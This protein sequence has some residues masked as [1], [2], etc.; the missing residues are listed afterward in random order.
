MA[1]KTEKFCLNCGV[2]VGGGVLQASGLLGGIG[3]VALSAWKTE[4][5]AAATAAAEKAGAAAGL[6]AG[7]AQGMAIVIHFLE[8]WGIKEFC[9]GLFKSIGNT[10]PYNDSA[11]IISAILAKKNAACSAGAGSNANAAIG[12]FYIK[13]DKPTCC[14]S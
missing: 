14:T 8:K 3:E 9:P 7:N 5:I 13:K 11:T 4:A 2:D 12:W 10:T 1:D 6:Q